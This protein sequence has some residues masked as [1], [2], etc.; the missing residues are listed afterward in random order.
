[1]TDLF[2]AVDQHA[3]QAMRTIRRLEGKGVGFKIGQPNL[4]ER[5]LKAFRDAIMDSPV[6]VDAKAADIGH[7]VYEGISRIINMLQ[8]CAFVPPEVYISLYALAG[9]KAI[10]EARRAVDNADGR[11]KLLAVTIPTDWDDED[12]SQ[13]FGRWTTCRTQVKRLGK[14][15]IDNGAHGIICSGLETRMVRRVIGYDP[16]IGNA[17]IRFKGGA[18]QDQKRVVTPRAA[19]LAGA[20]FLVMGRPLLNPEGGLTT[21]QAIAKARAE[22]DKAAET[23]GVCRR[24]TS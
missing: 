16:V 8:D 13:M 14:L 19:I 7:T 12:C 2:V 22:I 6:F 24:P 1:M 4:Y 9:P 21:A 5:G 17:G 11:A 10:Q 15:A 20:D 3:G 18:T 23:H